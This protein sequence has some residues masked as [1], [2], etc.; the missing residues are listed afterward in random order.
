[1]S[2]TWNVK[3]RNQ[4]CFKLSEKQHD[5]TDPEFLHVCL[6]PDSHVGGRGGFEFVL[7]VGQKLFEQVNFASEKICQSAR[8][9]RKI[10]ESSNDV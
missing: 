9:L 6:Q 5:K 7:P 10:D 3:C 1:M 2:K 8:R 4:K